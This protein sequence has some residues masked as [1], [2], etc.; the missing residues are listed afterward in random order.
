MLHPP[1]LKKLGT[2]IYAATLCGKMKS[3]RYAKV[4]LKLSLIARTMAKV[5][6]FVAKIAAIIVYITTIIL[7][8]LS[9]NT[10][11]CSLMRRS[12]SCISSLRI[13]QECAADA[14]SCPAEYALYSGVK[15]CQFPVSCGDVNIKV[16]I[17]RDVAQ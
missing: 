17:A 4:A 12:K 10:C 13:V 9:S 16:T 2:G 5:K 3:K 15:E 6:M 1:C 14:A 7:L 8:R 11:P